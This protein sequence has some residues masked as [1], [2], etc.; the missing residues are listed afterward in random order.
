MEAGKE[1]DLGHTGMRAME[2]LRV[3]KSYR[4]WGTD[5]NREYSALEAGLDRFLRLNKGDFTGRDALVRQQQDGVPQRFVTLETFPEAR[6]ERPIADCRGNEPLYADGEMI[7]RCTAGAY[8]HNV[9]KSLAMAYVKPE[10]AALGSELEVEI[11]GERFAA[12]VIEESPW[13][14]QNERLRA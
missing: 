11:L 12:K 1:F 7:G 8:G 10:H 14:P 4:M 5:L 3:E 6:D 9:G 13:D 2:V